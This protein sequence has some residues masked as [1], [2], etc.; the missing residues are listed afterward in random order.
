MGQSF[1]RF[2]LDK[3]VGGGRGAKNALLTL[4]QLDRTLI[5]GVLAEN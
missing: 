1:V 4:S 3:I 2:K 5:A